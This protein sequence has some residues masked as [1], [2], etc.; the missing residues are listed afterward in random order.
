VRA[1]E[2]EVYRIWWRA[3]GCRDTHERRRCTREHAFP[4]QRHPVSSENQW[5]RVIQ[6]ALKLLKNARKME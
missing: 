4:L 1:V 3:H 5:P 6:F 2:T